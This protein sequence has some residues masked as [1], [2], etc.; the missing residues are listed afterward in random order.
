MKSGDKH[1]G[2]LIY[3]CDLQMISEI[4]HELCYTI[5]SHILTHINILI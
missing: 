4:I 3:P 1:S 2:H 5:M